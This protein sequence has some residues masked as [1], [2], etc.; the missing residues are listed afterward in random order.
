[1]RKAK[2][3]KRQYSNQVKTIYTKIDKRLIPTLPKVAYKGRIVVIETRREMLSAVSY[4]RKQPLVSVQTVGRYP[5]QG[6]A[7]ASAAPSS[8]EGGAL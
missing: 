7:A 5:A 6:E 3:N 1:M 4:L 8:E 2:H